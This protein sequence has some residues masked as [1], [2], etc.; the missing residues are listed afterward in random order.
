MKVIKTIKANK[1][2]VTNGGFWEDGKG[3]LIPV[4][5]VNSSSQGGFTIGG[6]K[7]KTKRA[8]KRFALSLT[9]R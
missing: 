7:R 8:L 5:L 2:T 3:R 4:T 6:C 9:P 1:F